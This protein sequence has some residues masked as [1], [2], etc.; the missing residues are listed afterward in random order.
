LFQGV[1]PERPFEIEDIVYLR[2]VEFR[3]AGAFR[4]G[5]EITRPAWLDF[6]IDAEFPE[7]EDC[8]FI[9]GCIAVRG[10]MEK[11]V[12][13]VSQKADYCSCDIGGMGRRTGLVADN[14]E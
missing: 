2:T 5:Y 1:L 13:A 10:E 4:R 6:H 12:L 9:T 7:C 3:I 14:F 11:T 8:C